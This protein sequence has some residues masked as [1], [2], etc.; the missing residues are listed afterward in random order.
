MGK[1]GTTTTP[2]RPK[3]DFFPTPVPTTRRVPQRELDRL[4]PGEPLLVICAAKLMAG[5]P[6]GVVSDNP[7]TIKRYRAQLKTDWQSGGY[8]EFDKKTFILSYP[9]RRKDI[10]ELMARGDAA[11]RSVTQG[12]CNERQ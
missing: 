12:D 5:L 10:D 1:H 7:E 4:D 3:R 6:Y 11:A 9:P 2:P 8:S